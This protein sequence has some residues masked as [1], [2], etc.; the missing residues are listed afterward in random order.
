MTLDI[1][2]YEGILEIFHKNTFLLIQETWLSDVEFI[3]QFKLHFPGT[4]CIST[5]KMDTGEI[6]AGRPYGGVGICYYTDMKC[7][8]ENVTTT[9]KSICALTIS[10]GELCILLINVYM[11]SSN[12]RDDLDEYSNILQEISILCLKIATPHIIIGGDWNA[13][14]TRNDGRSKLFKE[15]I[16]QENLY[17]PLN[18]GI[19]CEPY[20]YYVEKR[21]MI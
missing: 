20:T 21:I 2:L 19:S 14:L 10:I 11:P 16:V 7:K 17:N 15:F 8:I 3:R 18:L 13:D 12:N 9:S 5:N 4:E 1:N 6:R